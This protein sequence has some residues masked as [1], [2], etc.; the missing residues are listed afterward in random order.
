MSNSLLSVMM[1]ISSLGSVPLAL[2]NDIEGSSDVTPTA[3][4]KKVVAAVLTFEV[5]AKKNGYLCTTSYI[6]KNILMIADHCVTDDVTGEVN[7]NKGTSVYLNGKDHYEV[8]EV[9]S[10]GYMKK[11]LSTGEPSELSDMAVVRLRP[12][13]CLNEKMDWPIIPLA[14]PGSLGSMKKDVMIVGAGVSTPY[15]QDAGKMR[16]GFNQRVNES[17]IK[18]SEFPSQFKTTIMEEFAIP[19]NSIAIMGDRVDV[20]VQEH[21]SGSILSFDKFKGQMYLK[22]NTAIDMHGDSGGPMIGFDQN[23]NPKVIGVCSMTIPNA[24]NA[25][26]SMIVEGDDGTEVMRF[27]FPELGEDPEVN[28]GLMMAYQVMIAQKL[29]DAGYLMGNALVIKDFTLKVE[30]PRVGVGLY[31]S[32]TEG[33]NAEFLKTSVA[34]ISKNRDADPIKCPDPAI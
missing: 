6:R 7:V 34:K 15:T 29:N 2:A 12:K 1:V 9:I 25:A 21:K 19:K 5:R 33:A 28:Q 3:Q 10:S 24:M 16:I 8:A 31:T 14:K 17:E 4:Q 11:V 32:I 26:R 30:S 27:P 18:K 23:G 22:P 13:V 20:G